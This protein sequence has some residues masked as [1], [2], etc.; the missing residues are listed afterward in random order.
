MG[1]W[2]LEVRE[3]GLITKFNVSSLFLK[4]VGAQTGV[5]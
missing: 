2:I 3:E 4:S 1:V 5:C